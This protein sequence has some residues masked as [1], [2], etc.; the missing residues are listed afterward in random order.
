MERCETDEEHTDQ[1]CWT[2]RNQRRVMAGWRKGPNWSVSLNWVWWS[3]EGLGGENACLIEEK[4]LKL[5]NNQEK[6][7]SMNQVIKTWGGWCD[8]NMDGEKSKPKQSA[9]ITKWQQS[10]KAIYS[11]SISPLLAATTAVPLLPAGFDPSA[12]PMKESSS[13]SSS[14]AV[15][16]FLLIGTFVAL[17][18][19]EGF[20]RTGPVRLRLQDLESIR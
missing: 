14:S 10:T 15:F 18:P 17:P 9:N 7:I 6:F 20:A 12:S 1:E 3:C 2:W 13:L 16:S 5:E 8:C 11:I 19:R 4:V